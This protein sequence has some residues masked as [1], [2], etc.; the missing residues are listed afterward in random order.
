MHVS[1]T[2]YGRDLHTLVNLCW[3]H[4]VPFH[5]VWH[6]EGDLL[7]PGMA[8]VHS[9][10]PLHCASMKISQVGA[11]PRTMRFRC[12]ATFTRMMIARCRS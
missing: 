11:G 10:M 6:C 2:R 3:K 4:G 9:V 7:L 8:A 1:P 5:A 12:G